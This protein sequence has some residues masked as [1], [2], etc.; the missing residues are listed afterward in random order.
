[1]F[2]IE[3]QSN[4]HK[5]DYIFEKIYDKDLGQMFLVYGKALVVRSS[6]QV[7]FFKLVYDDFLM[8]WNWKIYHELNIRGFIYYIKGNVRIQVCTDERIYFYLIDK[9]TLQP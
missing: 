4:K 8:T 3:H 5:T 6:S 7:L 9:D 2:A 1:V